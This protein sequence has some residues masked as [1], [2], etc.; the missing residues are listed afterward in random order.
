MIEINNLSYVIVIILTIYFVS[1]FNKDKKENY[2]DIV[3]P[4]PGVKKVIN[5]LRELNNKLDLLENKIPLIN[6]SISKQNDIIRNGIS[7]INDRENF[8]QSSILHN[9]DNKT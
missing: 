6:S 8:R 3:S 1:Q 7:D 4:S 9:L 2:L 5:E